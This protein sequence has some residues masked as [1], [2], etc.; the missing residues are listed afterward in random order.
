MPTGSTCLPDVK[1]THTVKKTPA[2]CL[3]ASP[4]VHASGHP[5]SWAALESCNKWM[6]QRRC[7]AHPR[8]HCPLCCP[9][10]LWKHNC[11]PKTWLCP[12]PNVM[13]TTGTTD[14]STPQ[15]SA[16]EASSGMLHQKGKKRKKWM[17]VPHFTG[18]FP[19]LSLQLGLR[20]SFGYNVCSS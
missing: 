16:K 3:K 14:Y 7:H 4:Q 18:R 13:K 20:T 11:Y 9:Q 17:T 8:H 2:V 1:R 10:T 5:Q 19:A 12:T 15:P 6:G